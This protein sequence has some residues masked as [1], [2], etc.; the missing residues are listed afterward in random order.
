MTLSVKTRWTGAFT[1][2][3]MLGALAVFSPWVGA[4]QESY[5]GSDEPQARSAAPAAAPAS[6]IYRTTDADGNV[7]FTDAPVEGQNAE[8]VELREVNTVPATPVVRQQ[9]EVE[10]AVA[11]AGYESLQIVSP[12]ADATFRNPEGAIVVSV[13]LEPALQQGHRQVLFVNGAAQPDMQFSN[14]ER[15]GHTL[16]VKVL[17]GDNNIQ[18]ESDAQ[19]VFIHRSTV[20][21]YRQR[22]VPY[23]N[24]APQV[25]GPAGVGGSAQSGTG[26]SVGGAASVGGGADVATPVRRVPVR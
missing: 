25:G 1:A 19:E 23:N 13:K 6:K 7:V 22:P 4:E 15:G 21:D 10:E 12:E 11:F 5:P 24:G 17:D 18:I 16:Q 2:L 3:G 8:E 9:A 14:P 26:A 20:S